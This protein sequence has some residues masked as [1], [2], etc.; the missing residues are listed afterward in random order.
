MLLTIVKAVRYHSQAVLH[1]ENMV[2][3]VGP[4]LCNAE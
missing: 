2:R 4:G 3:K 1:I